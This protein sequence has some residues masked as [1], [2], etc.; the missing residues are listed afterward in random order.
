MREKTTCLFHSSVT[1]S[2]V[3]L[4]CQYSGI[5][6]KYTSAVLYNYPVCTHVQSKFKQSSL[7]VS[8]NHSA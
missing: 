2:A 3:M 7:S 4:L 8:V 1:F 6:Y 5:Q